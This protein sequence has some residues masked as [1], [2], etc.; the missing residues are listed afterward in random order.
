V[1][2]VGF[3]TSAPEET[4]K[5]CATTLMTLD[6]NLSLYKR[7]VCELIFSVCVCLCEKKKTSRFFK[8]GGTTHHPPPQE[9][10]KVKTK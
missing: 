8:G 10:R 4:E 2:L 5:S 9:K 3:D 6:K 1:L 7:L